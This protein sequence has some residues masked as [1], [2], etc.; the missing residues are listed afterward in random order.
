M[1]GA[2]PVS[3][4][5]RRILVVV[6]ETPIR[7][8]AMHI[9]RRAG[10]DVETVDNAFDAL[11]RLRR[12]PADVVLLDVK[13]PVLDGFG[14]LQAYRGDPRLRCAPVVIM[15][16]DD[17]LRRRALESGGST[18]LRKPFGVAE[19]LGRLQEVL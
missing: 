13:M 15:S 2:E 18:F 9:L 3:P 11:D 17:Q 6:D 8:A 14:F 19:L 1:I 7:L 12:R 4:G 5:A 16:A 10:S